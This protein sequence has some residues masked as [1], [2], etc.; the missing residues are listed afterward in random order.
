M[1]YPSRVI[2]EEIPDNV[3][4]TI[5]PQRPN[6]IIDAAEAVQRPPWEAPPPNPPP[7]HLDWRAVKWNVD[8]QALY[9]KFRH[10]EASQAPESFVKMREAIAECPTIHPAAK[11][12][13]ISVLDKYYGDM[14][15][16]HF[17]YMIG[18]PSNR[19][20]PFF[21]Q[22]Y[23]DC[24]AGLKAAWE[25]YPPA[26]NPLFGAMPYQAPPLLALPKAIDT[27]QQHFLIMWGY[28]ELGDTHA[29]KM[30]LPPAPPA[31][32]IPPAPAP[33]GVQH[34]TP[35]S[36]VLDSV[37]KQWRER[38]VPQMPQILV[39]TIHYIQDCNLPPKLKEVCIGQLESYFRDML[40]CLWI[41]QS[42]PL[43]DTQGAALFQ[44]PLDLFIGHLSVITARHLASIDGTA[45]EYFLRVIPEIHRHLLSQWGF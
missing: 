33:S 10:D 36:I 43:Q 28:K 30:P 23:Q 5:Q 15:F 7:T 20:S 19:V 34:T 12:A 39:N 27:I 4:S 32:E 16:K 26:G 41:H 42:Q 45:F 1:N 44:E 35:T 38:T 6:L 11:D 24:I 14:Q 21:A 29:P 13:F 22:E 17:N 18:H 8:F 3:P 2:I 31:P 37:Q 25:K 9:R 40:K